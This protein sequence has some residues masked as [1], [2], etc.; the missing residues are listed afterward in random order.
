MHSRLPLCEPCSHRAELLSA[1]RSHY[2]AAYRPLW[3][4]AQSYANLGARATAPLNAKISSVA[5]VAAVKS[6]WQRERSEADRGDS[7]DAPDSG[8]IFK[9]LALYEMS[10][11]LGCSS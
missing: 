8:F 3:R 7:L 2:V 1:V 11:V 10:P 5:G 9:T 6:G 4:V